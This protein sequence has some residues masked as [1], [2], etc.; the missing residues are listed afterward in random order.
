VLQPS[1]KD[2]LRYRFDILMSKGQ[3][4]L[5]GLLFLA[6][7]ASIGAVALFLAASGLAPEDWSAARMVWELLMRTMDPGTVAGDSGGWG[8]LLTLLAVTLG[9]IFIFSTLIGL[10]TSQIEDT[11]GRFR[12]GRSFVAETGHVVILGWSPMIFTILEQLAIANTGERGSCV[13]ILAEKDKVEMEDEIAEKVPDLRGTRVVCRRGL[14]IDVHDLDIVNPL[15]ARSI[16][17]LGPEEKNPDV[18]VIKTIL[19]LTS[20]RAE[21]AEPF[22]ITAMLR[23]RRNLDAAEMVGGDEA[24][25]LLASRLTARVAAQSCRKSGLSL[26]YDQLLDFSGNDVYFVPARELAARATRRDLIGESF[27]AAL[28]DFDTSSLMGIYSADRGVELNPAMDTV[29]RDGDELLL[30]AIR[31]RLIQ[32]EQ[33][34]A[35]LVDAGA[36]RISASPPPAAARFLLLGW[37]QGAPTFIRELAQYASPGS[38]LTVVAEPLAAASVEALGDLANLTVELRHG[39]TT[40]RHE[41]DGLDVAAYQHVV[42]LSYSDLFEVQ[43]ADARTLVTLLHLRRLR[44]ERP[45]RRFSIVSEMLDV[46]NRELA[47]VAEPEDF[48][49]SHKLISMLMAQVSQNKHR[50]E[51]Y[52]EL[53]T[54]AGSELYFHPAGEY[55][56]TGKPVSFCTVVAAAR[57]RGE[58][59]LGY[60]LAARARDK[61]AGYGLALNPTKSQTVVF[62][63]PDRVLVLAERPHA[64]P[65]AVGPG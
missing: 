13:A 15:A 23:D 61:A 17:V 41:L 29:I 60:R 2:R 30:L 43:Q 28:L 36:I 52:Q 8:L 5:I 57:E 63:E 40:D 18:P 12:K 47:E 37:N 26:V 6:T 3:V 39:D 65:A 53:F 11:L 35:D 21:R 38:T 9:G 24:K 44:G 45:E 59:A 14:P 1:F 16:L 48:I 20:R 49:V 27:G 31:K 42:V 54:T 22:H 34:G 32:L 33:G 10:L 62:G 56:A 58:V 46:R 64:D 7:V 19:A 51:V 25:L 4:A 55:V 50:F